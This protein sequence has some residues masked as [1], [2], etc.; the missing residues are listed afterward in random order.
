MTQELFQWVSIATNL[1]IVIVGIKLVRHLTRMEFR[2]NTMWNT[3]S[4]KFGID[5]GDS[6]GF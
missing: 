6:E 1:S 5:E 4:K 2:V 3:F